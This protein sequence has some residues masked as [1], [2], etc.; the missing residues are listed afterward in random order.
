MSVFQERFWQPLQ[1]DSIESTL[2]KAIHLLPVALIVGQLIVSLRRAFRQISFSSHGLS[3]HS[4]YVANL[5]FMTNAVG[6]IENG[7]SKV[8]DTIYTRCLQSCGC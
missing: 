8:T 4:R 3:F 6:V 7:Y 5:N 2:F 1:T